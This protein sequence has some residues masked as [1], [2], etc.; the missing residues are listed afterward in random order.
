MTWLT[1]VNVDEL[2][3]I[4]PQLGEINTKELSK[5]DDAPLLVRKA[6]ARRFWTSP[7]PGIMYPTP[8][9]QEFN[10]LQHSRTKE[11]SDY[12]R[13]VV[14]QFDAVKKSYWGLVKKEMHLLIC[15]KDKKYTAL[16]KKLNDAGRQTKTPVVALV[17]AALASSLGL[18]AGVISGL[19]AIALFAALQIGINAY[20]AATK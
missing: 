6:L 9:P 10:E 16:R 3:A 20:C 5:P 12:E 4:C 14:K 15:T 2:V 7:P 11:Y 1:A 19:V 13:E 8:D 18:A 17:S